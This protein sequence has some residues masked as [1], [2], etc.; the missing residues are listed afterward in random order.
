LR[1]EGYEVSQ[2]TIAE[3]LGIT[4]PTGAVQMVSDIYNISYSND[5]I[6]WGVKLKL[7]S[8]NDLFSKLDVKLHETYLP[9][10]TISEDRFIDVLAFHFLSGE[11]I[12]C[13]FNYSFLYSLPTANY[14]HVSLVCDIE[15]KDRVRLLDPGPKDPGVKNVLADDLYLAIRKRSDGLWCISR[16]S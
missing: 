11:H 16:T 5:D 3:I 9:I 10:N 1:D 13:G 15:K 12:V 8:I 7:N 2:D 14:G 6:E 4:V